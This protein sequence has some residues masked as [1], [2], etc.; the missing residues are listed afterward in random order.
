MSRRIINISI[1][2]LSG[3]CL[4]ISMR[5]FYNIAIYVDDF[6]T[7]PSVVLGG[8][9]WLMMNWLKLGALALICVLSGINLLKKND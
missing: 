8:D 4:I 2:I 3:I 1:F 7:T 5:L 9:F 6:N